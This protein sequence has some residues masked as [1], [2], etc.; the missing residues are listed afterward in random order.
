[1][2]QPHVADP[3]RLNLTLPRQ[4]PT[5]PGLYSNPPDNMIAAA[6]RL[7]ALLVQGES[8]AAV[9]IRRAGELLQTTLAQQAAYSYSRERVHSTPCP[10]RSYSWHIE[11]PVVSSSER[12]RNHPRGHDPPH[13][14]NHA[15]VLV[16]QAR[17]CQEAE[18]A[19]PLA[20]HQQPQHNPSVS[21]EAGMTSRTVG[22]PCLVPA[23]HNERLP[24]DFKGCRKVPN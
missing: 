10:S 20:A 18:L 1:M 15:Q 19:A 24:K 8:P 16:D 12:H 23:L 22:V 14:V 17:A 2:V 3:H 7:V 21:V 9:E 13:A 5:P 11:S 4:V 6:S